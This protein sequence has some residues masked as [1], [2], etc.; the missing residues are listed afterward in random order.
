MFKGI[1]SI[2]QCASMHC[3]ADACERAIIVQVIGHVII[4][5]CLWRWILVQIS[6]EIHFTGWVKNVTWTDRQESCSEHICSK[7][8]GNPF[9]G[10][11]YFCLFHG[12]TNKHQPSLKPAHMASNVP[13]CISTFALLSCLLTWLN[14]VWEYTHNEANIE[15]YGTPVETV[16]LCEIWECSKQSSTKPAP[17]HTY[18]QT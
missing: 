3:T 14:I 16:R 12:L 8:K 17:R 18:R 7:L 15:K 13:M 6:L 9:S 11:R 5:P 2:F 10:R 1:I 4:L